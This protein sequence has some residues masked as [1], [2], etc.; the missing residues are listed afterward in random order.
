MA[1]R[2][3]E[4]EVFCNYWCKFFFENVSHVLDWIKMNRIFFLF[5]AIKFFLIRCMLCSSCFWL[6]G[7]L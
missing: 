4:I 3:T 7:K 5:V 2:S 1:R 6:I